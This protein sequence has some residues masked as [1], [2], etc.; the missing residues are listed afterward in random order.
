MVGSNIGAR[1][2]GGGM[3]STEKT[4]WSVLC[5]VTQVDA[6]SRVEFISTF[7]QVVNQD[8]K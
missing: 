4:T 6:S 2:G 1:R 5:P 7:I 8:G 3:E